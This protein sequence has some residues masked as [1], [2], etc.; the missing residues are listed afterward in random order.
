MDKLDGKGIASTTVLSL[1]A[2]IAIA[3]I[4][5]FAVM[6]IGTPTTSPTTT[7]GT[8][9]F[10][11]TDRPNAIG[12][13]ATLNVTVSKI[14][15]HS[16]GDNLE[17]T[18]LDFTPSTSTFDVVSLENGGVQTLLSTPLQTGS[19]TQVRLVVDN[20][21]GI[22]EIGGTENITVPSGELKLVQSFQIEENKTTTFVFDLN[23]VKTGDNAYM[24][25]PVAG[26]V[27]TQ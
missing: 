21:V 24:L 6:Q 22:L 16:A 23:V 4:A 26:K 17:N 13:F 2:V 20:A 19:Y 1:V 10:A 14:S 15:V 11:V 3:G 18:W 5:A 27:T 8:L 7:Y 9:Y 25:E 12:D